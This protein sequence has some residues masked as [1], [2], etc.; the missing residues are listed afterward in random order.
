MFDIERITRPNVKAL[1]PYQSAR[2]EF[3]GLASVS[4]DANENPFGFGLNRYPDASMKELKHQFAQFRSVQPDQVIFGNGSD[5]L[6]DLLIRAFCEPGQDKILVFPPVFSMYEVCAKINDVEIL[7]QPLTP[8][9]QIDFDALSPTLSD[10]N[11]KVIFVCSPNN[12]TGNSMDPSTIKSIATSFDGLVVVDEAYVDFTN[13]SLLEDDAPNIFI[14]NTFSKAFGLAGI[15]LGAGMGSKEV[16][17]VLHK[18]KPP[19]NVNSIT[20]QK[21]IEALKRPDEL[22]RQV[23][24]LTEERGKLEK[25]LISVHSV[26]KVY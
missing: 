13:E 14:L 3:G 8:D 20:Q 16:I 11:L 26:K 10:P 21:A 25:N 22:K 7:K 5:E 19:Y 12:P 23:E 24:I 9:F 6:I 17:E 1:K 2:D 15:R 4:L 18:I